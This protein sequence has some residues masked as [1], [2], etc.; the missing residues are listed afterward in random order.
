MSKNFG[1]AAA[2]YARF[3]AGFPDSFFDRLAEHGLTGSLTVVDVGTGTGALARGFAKRGARVIGI[4]PDERMLTQ[5]RQ[6]SEAEHVS[7]EYKAGTAEHLPL[8]DST[9]DIVTAGQCWHWFDGQKA[10]REFAR[11]T[12]P[13]GHVLIAHFDWIP[14]PGSVVEATE[15]LIK[16]HNPAWRFEGG[17]GIH[18]GSLV[19]LYA[20]GFRE[21]ETFSYDVDVPYT[22]EGWRGR[23]RACNGVGASLAAAE[24]E[25]FDREHAALLARDFPTQPLAVPHR[26][27][28][29]I[30]RAPGS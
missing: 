10:A 29:A 8:A 24:V 15:G 21:L 27:W 6:M 11:V 28:V 13:G 22:H 19:H 23:M 16:T 1:A 4:D 3:R 12:K 20:A 7:V 17:N 14:H 9:T 25:R 26:L 2:D 5:A 30:G 18:A